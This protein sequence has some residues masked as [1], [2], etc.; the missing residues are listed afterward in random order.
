VQKLRNS[1]MS[2]TMIASTALLALIG[3]LAVAAPSLQQD[4]GLPGAELS[5]PT[6]RLLLELMLIVL[7]FASLIASAMAARYFNHA[8][9]IGAMPIGFPVR[10]RWNGTGAVY[11]RR[12][13][14]LYGWSLRHL[15]MVA[16]TLACI[17][18][19]IAG[20]VAA[21]IVVVPSC[22]PS[23]ALAQLEHA[24]LALGHPA[25]R[26]RAGPVPPNERT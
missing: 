6:P 14:L 23:T 17:L 2:A 11:V 22:S 15:I 24:S 18:Y 25:G 10:E 12:A 7:L 26:M 1:L 19:P 3:T 4:F 21:V 9:F 20:P 16:P 13:G 8:S 5:I